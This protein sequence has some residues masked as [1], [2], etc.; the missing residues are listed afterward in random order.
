MTT[1]N[2][3][4]VARIYLEISLKCRIAYV[5]VLLTTAIFHL[6]T[7]STRSAA[8]FDFLQIS[9]FVFRL[10]RSNRAR[11]LAHCA[12]HGAGFSINN[13]KDYNLINQKYLMRRWMDK[14]WV[15]RHD[16]GMSN[17]S[18]LKL[19]LPLWISW[20]PTRMW[21]AYFLQH[22]FRINQLYNNI[23]HTSIYNNNTT[24]NNRGTF[25]QL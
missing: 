7:N 23:K 19:K 6:E 15:T 20:S 21:I 18:K 16:C 24:P 2:E 10:L 13:N 17:M 11:R 1:N 9:R 12:A 4:L 8:I 3:A 14:D 25:P 5:R 22:P